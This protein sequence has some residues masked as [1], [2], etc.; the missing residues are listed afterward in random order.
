MRRISILTLL[1]FVTF[2][3]CVAQPLEIYVTLDKNSLTTGE[4]LIYQIEVTHP[5]ALQFQPVPLEEHVPPG[6]D[7]ELIEY[8][9]HLQQQRDESSWFAELWPFDEEE[10]P[11]TRWSWRLWPVQAGTWTIPEI[12]ILS[13]QTNNSEQ[14]SRVLGKTDALTFTTRSFFEWDPE[15]PEL[16]VLKV[17][18]ELPPSPS[19]KDWIWILVAGI[20]ISLG[21]WLYLLRKRR[22]P[23]VSTEDEE[24]SDQRAFQRL[25]ELKQ[26]ISTNPQQVHYFYLKLSEIFRE[27]LENQFGFSA[28]SMTTQEFLPLL[29][30]RTPYDAE[31]REQIVFLTQKSDLVKYADEQSTHAEVEAAYNQVVKWIERI[32]FPP[33][34]ESEQ[35]SPVNKVEE[36]A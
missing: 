7:V 14:P 28:T 21:V 16:P 17:K 1:I 3:Y 10:I 2:A 30:S 31:E 35:E 32:A 24:R 34:E 19:T 6:I 11:T 23:P 25:R 15:N 29:Q 5:P 18:Q 13:L 26:F 8:V 22:K 9:P 33:T 20:L 4:F 12:E 36:A 27:Y